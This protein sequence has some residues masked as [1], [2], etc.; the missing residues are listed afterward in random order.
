ARELL[1][2]PHAS[3]VRAAAD[4]AERLQIDG[5]RW[6]WSGG[7][8]QPIPSADLIVQLSGEAAAALGPLLSIPTAIAA[9]RGS[10]T[11]LDAWPSFELS[12]KDNRWRGELEALRPGR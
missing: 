8:W 9:P 12:P 2:E 5:E 4:G 7:G 11:L 6:R 1:G 10:F 3:D